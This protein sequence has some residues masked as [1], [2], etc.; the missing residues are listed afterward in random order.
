MTVDGGELR[1]RVEALRRE[2]PDGAPIV[3]LASVRAR[4]R[5][6]V[7]QGRVF[8]MGLASP[9]MAQAE[10]GGFVQL[11]AA[12]L[13]V[14]RGLLLREHVTERLSAFG[15]AVLVVVD[16]LDEQA[17]GASLAGA[18]TVLTP[19]GVASGID[20]LCRALRVRAGGLG[21]EPRA[22]EDVPEVALWASAHALV[23]GGPRVEARSPTGLLF[24]GGDDLAHAR[25][26]CQAVRALLRAEPTP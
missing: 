3:P 23:L 6:E 14:F 19:T 4:D 11:E 2:L 21:P 9:N 24:L 1:Q 5:A 16:E 18:L 25:A 15:A 7:V 10:L 12:R 13:Q 22:S 20:A 26:R 17:L 8:D